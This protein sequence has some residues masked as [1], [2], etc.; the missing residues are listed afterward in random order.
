MSVTPGGRLRPALPRPAREG[1]RRGARDGAPRRAAVLRRPPPERGKLGGPGGTASRPP[2]LR[3]TAL[4]SGVLTVAVMLL[5]GGLVR[6]V[7][8]GSPGVYG[9]LFLLVG[10]ASA[11]WVRPADGLT[12]PIVA[13]IAYAAGLLVLTGGG[14]GFAGW[15]MAIV[16]ALAVEAG[17]VYGGTLLTAI[18]ALVRR[19]MRA[20]A[21]RRE[22][23]EA[24]GRPPQP[25]TPR[26]A[27]ARA[28]AAR[29]GA[30]T[31]AARAGAPP[32]AAHRPA[33]PGRG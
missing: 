17:W 5:L 30:R 21:R 9:L 19:A 3:L 2:G 23:E 33:G 26:T 25:R 28:D 27:E 32:G 12:T 13:P 4:G 15:V 29:T 20:A 10:P 22:R 8:D 6:L 18:A 14:D 1:G 16:T 11:L 31:D 7:L 24:R